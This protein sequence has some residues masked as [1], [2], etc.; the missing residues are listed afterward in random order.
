MTKFFNLLFTIFLFS[1]HICTGQTASAVNPYA[2]FL[3]S[4]HKSAKEYILGLFDNHDIVI[5]CER[6]HG[7]MTQYDLLADIISDKRFTDKAG[8]VF[9][10]VGVSTLNPALNT[11]LHTK[12]L[13]PD[14]VTNRIISFQRN[15][16]FWPVWSNKNYFY[17]LNKLYSINN[18]LPARDAVSVYPSDLPFTWAVLWHL[19]LL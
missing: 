17:F 14:S 13:A 5:V 19:R 15:C 16:S 6:N 2:S 9:T 7:E 3:K 1:S 12:N 11:F 4:Q 18:S 8:N 10:E